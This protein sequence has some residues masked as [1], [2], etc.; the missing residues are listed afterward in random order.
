ANQRVSERGIF[1]YNYGLLSVRYSPLSLFYLVSELRQGKITQRTH[2]R[3]LHNATRAAINTQLH[4]VIRGMVST[5]P[6][7]AIWFHFKLAHCK[8]LSRLQSIPLPTT[9]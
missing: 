4:G 6:A 9:P 2:R 5:K 8:T 7:G 3:D 1:H